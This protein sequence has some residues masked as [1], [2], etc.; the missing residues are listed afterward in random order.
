[1]LKQSYLYKEI[2]EQPSVLSRLLKEEASQI[3]SL[4]RA[5]QNLGI[6]HII[7]A[8][9]GTSDN[10]ARYAKYLLGTQNELTVTLAT[11]SLVSVYNRPPDF[12]NA[13]V[14]GISQSGQSPDIVS[15]LEEARRQGTLTTALTN[16]PDSPLAATSD[17]VVRLHA[18]EEKSVAATKTYTT[19]IM[20][21]ALFS[22]LLSEDQKMMAVLNDVPTQIEEILG[23][24]ERIELLVP[25]YRYMQRCVV[26]SRGF[27][28]ATAFETALKLKELT[29][30][31]VEPY[32]TADFLHG[33]FAMVDDG[34]PVIVY[35]AS[36]R[37][38]PFL[39]D[40][41]AKSI[42]HRAE[43][44]AITN[45]ADIASMTPYS[46]KMPEYIPEWASPLS[47]IVAGQL[48]AMYLAETRGLDIDTPRSLRKVTETL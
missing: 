39:R 26:V 8:A 36:G 7:I 3:Q 40:F 47:F 17:V 13:L 34:F 1:M 22:A 2:H 46:L 24:S 4:A 37:V 38:E 21:I 18:G 14:L 27:N 30:T 23:L 9:R 15:V 43:V 44:I 12:G 32:S 6:K 10:A 31:I 16:N 41:I 42:E 20:A 19:E 48:F 5:I 33:P 29:Y 25:R 35:A 11:P 45:V 28:Y